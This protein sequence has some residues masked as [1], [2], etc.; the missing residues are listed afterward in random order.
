L[1]PGKPVGGDADESDDDHELGQCRQLD[2]GAMG[3]EHQRCAERD[4]IAGYVS[5]EETVRAE[6]AGGVHETAGE[7][8][9]SG[10]HV[11]SRH[12][13]QWSC[14]PARAVG[15]IPAAGWSLPC[16]AA[17]VA[18]IFS[19]KYSY[20]TYKIRPDGRRPDPA[21]CRRLW[22]KRYINAVPPR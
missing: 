10:K 19:I 14:P 13:L 21:F 9:A 15:P 20:L 1:P 18:R 12:S 3:A 5:S 7:A 6:K 16:A 8:Q 17:A 22:P 2:D 11:I 4:E